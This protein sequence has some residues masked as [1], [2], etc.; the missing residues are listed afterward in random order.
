MFH[1]KFS[2]STAVLQ[3]S[4]ITPYFKG[5]EGSIFL[6]SLVLDI[7]L[8]YVQV[9]F[10]DWLAHSQPTQASLTAWPAIMF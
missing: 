7:Y 6:S 5:A 4:L 1:K 9:V 3:K 2:L 8:R 10:G